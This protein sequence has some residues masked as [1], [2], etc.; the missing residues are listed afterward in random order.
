M[1]QYTRIVF[2]LNA[3]YLTVL[4]LFCLL[5]PETMIGLYGGSNAD[6]TAV[7]LQVAFRMLGVKL[8]PFGVMSALIAGNPDDN[9]VL[10][11][12]MGLLSVLT[13]VCYGIV[14]GMY[15][16]NIGWIGMVSLNVLSQVFVLVAVVFYN[17]KKKAPQI[18]TRSRRVA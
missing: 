10:R 5:A 12:M 16:L 8:I 13:L 9:P 3:V 2:G 11:A 14:V 7:M 17:G 1:K 15:E 4:G 18:I 6:E